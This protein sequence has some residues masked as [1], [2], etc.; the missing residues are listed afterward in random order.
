[1]AQEFVVVAVAT[2]PTVVVKVEVV[3]ARI[4][5]KLVVVVVVV[6]V[7]VT[8]VIVVV[9]AVVNATVFVQKLIVWKQKA[10]SVDMSVAAAAMQT[11][12]A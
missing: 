11:S 7:A 5:R 9:V 2:L 3:E 8:G 4:I 6:H 12:L 1:M 10:H